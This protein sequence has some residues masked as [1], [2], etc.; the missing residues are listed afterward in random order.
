VLT[1]YWYIFPKNMTDV[2]RPHDLDD[3]VVVRAS[4][5][6]PRGIAPTA[7]A[8]TFAA[9]TLAALTLAN[10]T[11]DTLTLATLTFANLTLDTLTLAAAPA[12]AGLPGPPAGPLIFGLTA[13]AV[14]VICFDSGVV[15]YNDLEDDGPGRVCLSDSNLELWHPLLKEIPRWHD[16]G[17]LEVQEA[18]VQIISFH[19]S[20]SK[21]ALHEVSGGLE[22]ASKLGVVTDLDGHRN[23]SRSVLGQHPRNVGADEHAHRWRWVHLKVCPG[24]QRRTD[25]PLDVPLFRHPDFHNNC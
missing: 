20:P 16:S 18:V 4:R 5:S 8:L 14:G 24:E 6:K 3:A 25:E 12:F 13:V 11:L 19:D 15:V 10:L 22:D 7:A 9:L 1:G 17:E 23:N 21:V 2:R